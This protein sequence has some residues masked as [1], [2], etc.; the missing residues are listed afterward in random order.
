MQQAG[1]PKKNDNRMEGVCAHIDIF[2]LSY[3]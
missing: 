2:Y 3:V 1:G